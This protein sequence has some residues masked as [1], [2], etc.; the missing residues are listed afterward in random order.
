MST[1][2]P[3]FEAGPP[4]GQLCGFKLPSFKF[5]LGF[6]VPSIKFPPPLPTFKPSLGINCSTT[7]PI[8]VS[9]GLAWGGGRVATSDPDVDREL[10]A[11]T[12]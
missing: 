10:D 9:A 3:S 11:A 2:G 1:S 4:I 5:S 12:S 7:N 6:K 8:N